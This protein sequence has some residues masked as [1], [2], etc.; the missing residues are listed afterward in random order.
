MRESFFSVQNQTIVMFR[1]LVI[2]LLFAV[3]AFAANVRLYLKDGTYHVVREYQTQPDRVRYYSI[4]RGDWEELPLEMVDLKRT[5]AEIQ[6]HETA[7]KEDA[8]AQ[9]ADEK[10]IR[11][12]RR[13]VE[14]IPMEPGVFLPEGDALK[15][16]KLAESKMVT[17]K[18]RS[19]LAA[20]SPIPMI[21]GKTTV[22][23]AGLKAVTVI[24]NERPDFYIRL[25]AEERF[26]ILRLKPGKVN[27]LVETL[28][29]IPVSKEVVEEADNVEI[30]R[31][32]LGDG[33]YK[34]WPTKPLAPG[35][36]AVVEYTEG[37]GNIQIWDFSLTK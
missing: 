22:E 14:R 12:E 13:E 21:A 3:G 4:E 15:V 8:A 20:V 37:K 26:G 31:K 18:R 25:S 33:L 30:F 17:N 32:Q 28:N 29:I 9:D 24:R 36:Y 11:A 2:T 5:E 27:R 6:Q 1:R 7:L 23:L 35:E 16:M 10:A 34:I 19:I